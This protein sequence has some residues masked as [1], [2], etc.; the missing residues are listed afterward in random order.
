MGLSPYTHLGTVYIGNPHIR[1]S[2]F[3]IYIPTGPAGR[4]DHPLGQDSP[5]PQ[6]GVPDSTSP[7][8]L[9]D[10]PTTPLAGLPVPQAGVQSIA[11]VPLPTAPRQ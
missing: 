1:P 3:R 10:T 5:S 2:T 6:A 7:Q 4:S 11:G 8:A 9:R